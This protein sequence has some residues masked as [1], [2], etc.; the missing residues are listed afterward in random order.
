LRVAILHNRY[1]QRGGEDAVVE[2]EAE[3]LRK[4]GCEVA[5]FLV[6]SAPLL[7]SPV[8]RLQAAARARWNPAM[9]ER[10]ASFLAEHPVDV[11]HVHNFFPLLS[12]A[13]HATLHALGI[14]VVQT[15]HNYRLACANAAFLRDGRPCE[16][17]AVRGPWRAVRFGCLRGS[18]LASAVWAE[19]TWTHR[20]RGTWHECVDR[21]VAPSEFTRR[22]LAA[23]GLPAERIVVKPNPVA[24]PGP[25][26]PPGR[27]GLYAGR[28]SPEK[29]VGLLLDAWRRLPGAPPLAIAGDGPEAGRL[30]ERA[31]GIPG[32]RFL[33]EVSRERVASLLTGAAFAVAPSVWYEV[34]PVAVA[35]A[36]A[37]GRAV[38]ASDAGALAE[39][40]EHGA[41]GLLFRSGDAESLAGACRSLLDDAGLAAALGREARAR[42]EDELAPEPGTRRLLELYAEVLAA[43]SRAN[44]PAPRRPG[45]VVGS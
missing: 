15:L 44:R 37:A 19:A 16:E 7:R 36:M 8:A 33:G 13:V 12:P 5:L 38:V 10:V 2:T 24:D 1:A 21:F 26:G 41:T 30:R 18:R 27:G 42:Y 4:A 32:V 17:C 28:L 35:E 45:T 25:P 31:S 23:A 39:L 43:S 6:D 22:K 14:P 29:G 40:V 11:A 9:V 20:R 3:L 34:F